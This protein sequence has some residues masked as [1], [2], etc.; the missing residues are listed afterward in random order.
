MTDRHIRTMFPRQAAPGAPIEVVV[1]YGD[2]T[3]SVFAPGE[4]WLM[5]LVAELSQMIARNLRNG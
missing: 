1:T 2:G 4:K 5:Q 3:H